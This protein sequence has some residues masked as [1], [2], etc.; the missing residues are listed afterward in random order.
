LHPLRATGL[1]VLQVNVGKVCNQS[2][3]HC[4]VEAGPN[5]A[6]AMTRQTMQWCL[7]A[8]SGSDIR[9]LDIT[10]G[11]PE[12]NPNFRWLIE[13]ARQ[14]GREVIDRSNLTVLT[15]PGFED[16]PEFLAEHGVT[17]VASLPC[18]LTENVDAQ[19]GKGV[20]ERSIRAL[21]R[22]NAL[23]YGQPDSGLALNLVYNPLGPS[24]PLSQGTLEAVYR[25]E[26]L[27]RYGIVFNRLFTLTNAPIGRFRSKLL[28]AN[29]YETYLN[30]LAQAFSPAA[31]ADV[32]CR[33]MLSVDWTGRLHDCDF[34]QMLALGLEKV[35]PQHIRNFDP[36]QLT[37]RQI[38]TGEHCYACTA[39]AGS[40]CQGAILQTTPA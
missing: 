2:C 20:F 1:E 8:L 24:L 6:E 40:G 12:L 31:A 11:A 19:R 14:F 29:Q 7:E 3:R 32:M 27:A 25:Q 23:G 35:R 4:H 22:L 10:G 16:L 36:D 17:I 39:G 15:L 28:R 37:G 9:V 33:T 30:T 5:R 34:N 21:R 13:E 26:L 38:V 18:Y